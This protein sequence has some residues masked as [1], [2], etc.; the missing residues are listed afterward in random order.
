MP[1][2]REGPLERLEPRATTAASRKYVAQPELARAAAGPVPGRVPEP[3]R[4]DRGSRRPARHPAHR[5]PRRASSPASR[6]SP[7]RPKPTCCGSTWRSR[8]R[9]RPNRLGILGGDLAG[10]PNGRRLTDDVVTIEL[11]AVAGATYPLVDPTLH[12][13]RRRSPRSRTARSATPDA[14]PVTTSRTSARP[15]AA[16]TSPRPRTA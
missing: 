4:A 9:R 15:T 2:A 11:R 16:T 10:F 14:V 1:M 7:A 5:H 3:C 6:T 13:R 8:R 12:A